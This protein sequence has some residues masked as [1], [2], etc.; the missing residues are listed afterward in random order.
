ME[1][2]MHIARKNT[3]GAGLVLCIKLLQGLIC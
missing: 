1:E 3:L 2:T